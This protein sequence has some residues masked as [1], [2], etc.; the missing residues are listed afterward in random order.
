MTEESN[1]NENMHEEYKNKEDLII[2]LRL[3]KIK[4]FFKKSPNLVYYLILAFITWLALL[5]RTRNFSGLK[6]ITTGTWTLGPDL[7]PFLFLRW[8]EYVAEHG[9]LFVIDNMRYVPLGYDVSGEAKLLSYLIEW[10]YHFLTYLPPSIYKFLPGSPTPAEMTIIYAANLFPVVMF[11]FTCVAFFILTRKIFYDSFENKRY[12]NIIALIS[13]FFLSVIPSLLPRTIAGIPEKESAGF[14]FIFLALYFFISAFKSKNYK[15]ILIY[16]FLSGLLTGIMALIWG[17]VTFVFMTIG[18]SVFTA[19]IFGLFDK[20][21]FYGLTLWIIIFMA[22]GFAFSTRFNLIDVLTSTSTMPIF[23][24]WFFALINLFLYPKIQNITY[25]KEI[26]HKWHINGEIFSFIVGVIILIIVAVIIFGIGFF[27][28]QISDLYNKLIRPLGTTRFSLTVAENRQP[29]FTEWMGEFGPIIKNIPV[30]FWLFIIGSVTLFYSLIKFVDKK[31]K[32]YLTIIYFI[33]LIALIFSRYSPSGQ[34]NGVSS[35]SLLLFFGSIIL[36]FFLGVYILLNY[37][38][39]TNE[40]KSEIDLGIIV[41]LILFFISILAARSAVRFIMMLVPVSSILASYLVVSSIN[42]AAKQ[43]DE[44]YKIISFIIVIILLTASVYSGS[45]FYKISYNQANG[46]IPGYYNFQWQKAMSW[47]RDN[48]PQNAV[49]SHWWDY[50]YWI[51]TMGKRAT[52][53]DGGN[54]IVYWDHLMGREVLTTPNDSTALEF[55]YTHN[56]THLL[57][58]ST[59]IGKYSAFSS[60]GGDINNDRL[61]YFPTFFIDQ[62]NIQ[63]TKDGFIYFYQ[64]QSGLD[65]DITYEI[66]GSKEIFPSENSGI[67]RII[68]RQKNSGEYMQPS[69]IFVHSNIKQMEI[70]LRYLYANNTLYD[71]KSGINAGVYAIQTVNPVQNNLQIDDKGALFYLSK[72]TVDSLLVRK[73]LFGEEGNFK[74][75]HTEPSLIV[76]SI[77][78]QGANI[79]DIVY[80]QGNFQGPIKIWEISYPSDTK[81]NPDYLATSFPDE[82]LNKV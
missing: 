42:N 50:G 63:E 54:A 59:D 33:S 31:K 17:G 62:K 32:L 18:L 71:Y 73:Y 55:L 45:Y 49:F 26:K 24:S 64:G 79:N 70:P 37:Y 20:K 27:T 15:P 36:F 19:F 80:F 3:E 8:A 39:N 77:K 10:F 48:T 9:K 56:A 25:I 60:I 66:N 13:T 5:I 44:T 21:R 16:F 47:V 67:V 34:L 52:V 1:N 57:I 35:V 41:L 43:K 30:F 68:L 23:G 7:D 29:F 28:Y 69:A 58:D 74:L 78:S 40:S 76:S 14:F 6:D 72:R 22:L 81:L 12:P 38:K 11:G 82:K 53:L 4:D 75:V 46:Y 2:E 51:Q 65:E 61:S